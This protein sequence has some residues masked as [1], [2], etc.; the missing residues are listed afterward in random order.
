M[1]AATPIFRAIMLE[2]ERRRIAL[3]MSMEKFSEFAGLPDRYYAKALRADEPSGRQASWATMQVI[4]DALFPDG[5]DL[6][7]NARSG[8]MLD[9]LSMQYKVRYEQSMANGKTRRQHLSEIGRK[10]G[11]TRASRQTPEERSKQA[12]Y[13]A[14]CRHA[15]RRAKRA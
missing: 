3:G 10:G 5:Y 8:P 6:C 12:R 9:A 2:C 4:F 13:A 11:A 14:L 1:T 7:V 15:S